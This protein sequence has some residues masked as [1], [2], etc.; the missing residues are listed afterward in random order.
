MDKKQMNSIIISEAIINS[1]KKLKPSDM[2]KNPVMF[3]VYIGAFLTTAYFIFTAA[4]SGGKTFDFFTLH[5]SVWLWLTVIFSNFAEALA[6]SRGKATAD[7]LKKMKKDIFAKKTES[8][9][10]TQFT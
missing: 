1:L 8:K 7:T 3:C 4:A 5:I 10:S 6:E 2:V 9:D